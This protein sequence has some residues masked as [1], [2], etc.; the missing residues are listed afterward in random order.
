MGPEEPK[1]V[2]PAMTQGQELLAAELLL[3]RHI[4]SSRANLDGADAFKGP[5]EEAAK[6]AG[7]RGRTQVVW[8]LHYQRLL[9]AKAEYERPKP[10]PEMA[11][12]PE[13][14][15]E[16]FPEYTDWT[17]DEASQRDWVPGKDDSLDNN[18]DDDYSSGS[19]GLAQPLDPS[20]ESPGNW[21][22]FAI[23]RLEA[24]VMVVAGETALR[25]VE[26]TKFQVGLHE[27]KSR[28][29]AAEAGEIYLE[30]GAGQALIEEAYAKMNKEGLPFAERAESY[31]YLT[32]RTRNLLSWAF[33]Y[34][35]VDPR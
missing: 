26:L 23:A 29:L 3:R 5:I 1:S 11:S 10:A 4:V 28:Q 21:D 19:V 2:I 17:P 18:D 27:Y 15:D 31:E 16:K 22:R 25:I 33:T 7:R 34:A 35:T 14:D 32:F 6:S 13:G 8:Q 9:E 12:S 24:T 30:S 20:N